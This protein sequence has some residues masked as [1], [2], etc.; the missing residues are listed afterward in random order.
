MQNA[1]PKQKICAILPGL[2]SESGHIYHYHLSV[3]RAVESLGW[4]YAALVPKDNKIKVLPPNWIPVLANDFWD[5]PKTF[6]PRLGSLFRNFSPIRRFFRGE[7]KNS[8]AVIFIEHFELQNLASLCLSLCFLN[9]CF[10][11]WILHRFAYGKMHFKTLI[12]RAF[13]W[14]LRKKLGKDRFRILTDSDLLA[15]LYRDYFSFP[16][17]VVPI[18]HTSIG[19]KIK[20]KGPLLFWWPGAAI[21]ED[22]GLLSI[23]KLTKALR[24]PDM[25]QLVL[26]EKGKGF[27]PISPSLLYI[28]SLLSSD[29]YNQWMRTADLVLLPYSAASY[30]HRTSGIFVEAV[31]LGSTPVVSRGTWMAYELAKYDLFELVLDQEQFESPDCL[32]SLVTDPK[33]FKKLERMRSEYRRFHSEKGFAAALIKANRERTV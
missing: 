5:R 14:Y 20:K 19:E 1:D 16:V 11:F 10:Q 13:H 15:G 32:T 12:F 17:D 18:P 9:P 24:D 31:C 3:Q 2:F 23:Q 33:I 22:R 28:P 7:E 26:A 30:A 25:Y 8:D 21:H 29:E 27:F 4:K 6:F